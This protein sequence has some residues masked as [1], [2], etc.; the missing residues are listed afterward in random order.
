M[1]SQ[2]M[3]V[4][5]IK[6]KKKTMALQTIT[7]LFI[8]DLPIPTFKS[9]F[10][11]QQISAHHV[12]KIVCRMDALEDLSAS[13]GEQSKNFLGETI[14]LEIQSMEGFGSYKTLQFKG[15]VTQVETIKGHE[16]AQGDEIVITAQSP[17][18]L[19]EDGFHYASYNE[20]TLS[21]II[22]DVFRGYDTSQLTID[23]RPQND[24]PIDYSVQHHESSYN[25]AR[26]LASQYGEWFYYDGVNLVFGQPDSEEVALT[27]GIDLKEYRLSLMP[28]SQKYK[29]FTNDYLTDQVQE[30]STADVA[31]GLNGLN[32][33]V[34]DKSDQIFTQETQL[35]HATFNDAQVQSRLDKQVEKQRKAIAVNQVKIT[36]TS[37]NP[38]V[39][40]G[41]LI[42]VD[43]VTY[44]I[45]KV[46][47]TNN[48][49]GDY[50]NHFEGVTSEDNTYPLTNI[51]NFPKS[52]TQTAIVKDNADPEGLGRVKVQFHWQKAL[53]EQTPWIRIV[54]PHAGGDK[55]FHFIPEVGEEVL[56]GFEGGNAE[57]PYVMGSLY[58]GT[59]KAEAF[60][61][62]TNDIKVIR[63]RSGHTIALNDK[64]DSEF[65][66]IT[67]KK[68]NLITINTAHESITITALKD[69]TVNAGENMSLNA[70]NMKINVQENMDVSVGKN[71]TESIKQDLEISTK[72]SIEQVF[73]N[74]ETT[75]SKKT[76]QVSGELIVQ[77]NKGKML[78][79]SKGKLTIQSS[80]TIDYGD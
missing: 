7:D 2:L 80:D 4:N 23:I 3:M 74:K 34:A 56:I 49:T 24:I 31:V 38:G 45:I 61:S 55:G 58:N 50:E 18:F 59:G 26:R 75:V 19:A 60:M 69:V 21:D 22:Y 63:T 47:H 6:L 30:K 48:D 33:F 13:L 65:I 72:N 35:L 10:L 1:C 9:V 17:S 57:H 16:A 77:A 46:V 76:S 28:Q 42:N 51:N 14:A 43:D 25:Y 73:N 32:D 12:L 62:G 37:E 53:G 78:I 66:N 39:K 5:Y 11:D 8:G 70:K 52:E 67:D 27:Y 15:V 20:T 29:I 36:G 71:K 54:T 79:D 68:G 40:L 44:R 64:E 41:S